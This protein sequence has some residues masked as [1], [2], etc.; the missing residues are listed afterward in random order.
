MARARRT[1]YLGGNGS[2]RLF[3]IYGTSGNRE[4]PRI[5]VP[6]TNPPRWSTKQHWHGSCSLL[7][8]LPTAASTMV[9]RTWRF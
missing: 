6:T 4:M 5:W 3:S 8:T 9:M 7:G 2:F 1:Q